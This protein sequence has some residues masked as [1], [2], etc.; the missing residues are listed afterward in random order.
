[1]GMKSDAGARGAP[2][3]DRGGRAPR[4]LRA[5][6]ASRRGPARP[7][8]P[9]VRHAHDDLAVA[10]RHAGGRRAPRRRR[11]ETV[12][13]TYAETWDRCRRLVG[14]L[15]GL[16]LEE[17]DRVA[18]VGPELPPLPRALP[19]GP[20]RGHGASC[21]STSATPTPS[22]ATRSRTPAR[23][24]CS[25]ARPVG[26]LPDCVDDASSTWA[27]ATRRCSPAP[28]RPTSRTTSARRTS[29]GLFYTG[30]TTG[31]SKGVML[32][33]RNLVANATAPADG[34]AVHAGHV[35]ARSSRRCSTPPARS[36]CCR[37]SGTPAATSCCPRS[38]PARRSTSSSASGSRPRSSCR[39]M[40]AAINEEQLARPRDVSSL[41]LIAFGGAP[42]ATET[43][44]RA[45][46]AFPGA[47][48]C[49]STA[50]RRRRRSRP[51][52][53]ASRSA[54]RHAARR[55]RAGS[56]RSAS[57]SR[58][59]ARTARRAAAGEVGEV[60]VR[61]AERD[62][63]ATGTSRSETAAALVD[64]WYLTGDLGYMDE[65]AYVYLVDRAKDMIVTGGENVYSTEVEDVL[66]RHPAVLEA[67][68]FGIP[69]ER[70]GEAVHAVVVPRAAGDR[71]RADRALP[72][73]DRR[74]Q[75]A[76]GDRAAQR[77]A[78]EVGRREGAQA[79]AARAALGGA[80]VD[81]VGGVKASAWK[82]RGGSAGVAVGRRGCSAGVAVRPAWLLG[83][84]RRFRRRGGCSVPGRVQRADDDLA[85]SAGDA[86]RCGPARRRVRG[87]RAHLRGDV[88]SLPA[89]R[90]RPA[91]ARRRAGRPGRR[92]GAELAPLPRAL[93]GRPGGRH[94]ARP[95][96]PPPRRPGAALRA[97]RLG[98]EGAVHRPRHRRPCRTAS[99][100]S[101]MRRTATRRCSPAPS[102]RTSPTTSA[103]TTS[104]GCSTPAARPASPRA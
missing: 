104:P 99:S 20:R 53:P 19:G 35:L 73:G 86:G 88:G 30:G 31:A 98:R 93:P 68:V 70:W 101:S 72:R 18:V 32:T 4:L 3:G 85:P 79:G 52:C 25:P 44:R 82:R 43:L 28:R 67:A 33:H 83:P 6:V 54:A 65:Q 37:R 17:G 102:P 16:G 5:R 51:R 87:R 81:G 11:A 57:R 91:R 21:R 27:T 26:D 63:R 45:H 23:R 103:R 77:A 9:E 61:G 80:G 39:R 94:G 1:M 58:S 13:L 55:A 56:R 59:G 66:Y 97:R 41:R 12:S 49:T 46:E 10:A 78:A 15:R 96:E 69:D 34:L 75:G 36:P 2:A 64:G 7:P 84:S 60:V 40:L 29:P 71:G 76:E 42:I 8:S 74:L 48:C 100:R 89:A 38:T 24:C 62:G 92:G 50:R 14:A 47:G 90:R 95:A 22:C